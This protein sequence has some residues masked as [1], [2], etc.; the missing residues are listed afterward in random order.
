MPLRFAVRLPDKNALPSS[1]IVN[2]VSPFV[3]T[4]NKGSTPES[5][6]ITILLL[7]IPSMDMSPDDET[8]NAKFVLLPVNNIAEAVS[9]V[10]FEPNA[11]SAYDA[12]RAL[13]A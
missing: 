10:L 3:P 6:I 13:N 9:T 2:K 1:V 4:L 12:V 7:F 8:F 11:F 5:E